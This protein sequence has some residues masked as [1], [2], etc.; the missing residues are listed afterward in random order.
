[1][2]TFWCVVFRVQ[3]EDFCAVFS[4]LFPCIAVRIAVHSGFRSLVVVLLLLLWLFLLL[5]F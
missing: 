4:A 5:G 1:M 3:F 2:Y